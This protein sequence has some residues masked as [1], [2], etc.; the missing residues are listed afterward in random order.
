[1]YGTNGGEYFIY[2]TISKNIRFYDFAY[3][4]KLVEF[5][6]DYWHKNPLF[7][8]RDEEVTKADAYKQELATANGKELFIVWEYNYYKNPAS[9][10]HDALTFLT[11]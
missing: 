6:G 3:K 7:Y 5:H 2:D 9:T 4:N 8:E 10:L 11:T 1:M